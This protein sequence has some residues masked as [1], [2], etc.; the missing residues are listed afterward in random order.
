MLQPLKCSSPAT[1]PICRLDAPVK[2]T[3]PIVASQ[4]ASTQTFDQLVST[5]SFDVAVKMSFHNVNTSFLDAAVQTL[6]HSILFQ[7]VSTQMG[8]HPSSSFSLDAVVKLLHA[9]LYYAIPKKLPMT[10]FL[11]NVSSRTVLLIVRARHRHKVALVV[12]HCLHFLDLHSH[13]F[14]F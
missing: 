8:E 13:Q 11:L 14:Q 5:L 1:S 6:P 4:N 9:V 2:T 7:D 12:S 3:P 10:E